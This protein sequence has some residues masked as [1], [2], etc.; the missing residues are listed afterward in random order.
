VLVTPSDRHPK[1][2]I[3]FATFLCEF[4]A[5]FLSKRGNLLAWVEQSNGPS[6]S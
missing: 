2:S 5:S 6:N 3:R 4:S 1:A